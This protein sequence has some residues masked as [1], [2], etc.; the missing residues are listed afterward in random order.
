MT[1]M[2]EQLTTIVT[3][4]KDEEYL[5]FHARRLVECAAHIVCGHLLLQDANQNQELF[6][7][8]A[9]VYVHFGQIEVIK[10]YNFVSESGVDDLAYFKPADLAEIK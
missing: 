2:F 5:E 10:N 9:E 3:S 6:R 1:Q 7:R 8:S 4:P